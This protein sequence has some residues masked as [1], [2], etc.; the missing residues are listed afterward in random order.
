LSRSITASFP[1]GLILWRLQL[2]QFLNQTVLSRKPL[3]VVGFA[4][5]CLFIAGF[6]VQAALITN[7]LIELGTRLPS[8]VS[9]L[10][11]VLGSAY[12]FLIVLVAFLALLFSLNALLLNPDLETL[13]ASP[14]PVGSV[15]GGR[16]VEQILRLFLLSLLFVLPSVIVLA[17][18][19]GSLAILLGIPLVLLLVPGFTVPLVSLIALTAVRFLPASRGREVIAGLGVAFAVGINLL[20]FLVNPAFNG[21][22]FR[23]RPGLFLPR[24]P[25]ATALWPP[26]SWAGKASASLI[27]GNPVGSL[28]WLALLTALSALTFSISVALGGRLYRAGWLQALP[29]RQRRRRSRGFELAFLDWLDPVVA[30]I[31]LKDWR[32]RTRDLAQ[33]SRFVVPIVFLV[34]LFALRGQAVL[35]L[36]RRAGPGPIPAL[37][38]ISFVWVIVLSL[39]SGLGLTAVSLEGRAIWIFKSSPNGMRKLLLAKWWATAIPTLATVLV[40]AA[41]VEAMVGPGI[42]WA[43]LALALLALLAISACGIMVG[44]GSFW[45][46]FDWID[47]RRMMNP[48]GAFAGLF[49]QL[50]VSLLTAF[51][52]IVAF[53]ISTFFRIRIGLTL[54]AAVV[55][56]GIGSLMLAYA[57]Y[58]IGSER[59]NGLEAG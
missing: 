30:A 9:S 11:A 12:F 13:L 23:G 52:L 19:L 26:W 39:S 20:N 44:V 41:I 8:S 57:A 53:V 59:L 58:V 33:L 29:A 54:S 5:V 36:L 18:H 28:R 14:W 50:V 24:A 46:R 35:A 4:V 43:L 37:A 31:A 55:A 40:L 48:I 34:V 42:G 38:G 16:M 51:L 6:W 56:C 25:A 45:A 27:G 15:L 22:N 49:A 21:A 10:E 1:L 2:R 7:F 17:V 3:K 47:A 32:L